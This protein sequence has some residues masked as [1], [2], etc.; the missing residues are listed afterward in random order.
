MGTLCE[1]AGGFAARGPEVSRHL[2]FPAVQTGQQL[3]FQPPQGRGQ[4][5]AGGFQVANVT[6][7]CSPPLPLSCTSKLDGGGKIYVTNRVHHAASQGTPILACRWTLG[8]VS[9]Q[10]PEPL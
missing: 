10:P 8:L 5:P 6:L 1:G 3:S 7:R 4:K 2:K 9:L